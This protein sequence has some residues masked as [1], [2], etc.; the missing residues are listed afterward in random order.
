MW[1]LYSRRH[2]RCGRPS[3]SSTMSGSPAAATNVGSQSWCCTIS[4]EIEPAWICPGQRITSGM[5]KAPSQL[6]VF[7]LRNGVV[8]ASGQLFAC[9]PLS[10]R[11]DDDRVVGDARVRRAC[12]ASRRR[13]RSW[14]IIVSW[15]SD[16][17][18]PAWPTL[19]GLGWVNR[20][21]WVVLIHAK[22]GVS[23]GV[24]PLDEVERRSRRCRRR[25]S[26]SA[27]RRAG[28]CPRWSACRHGPNAG[29]SVGSSSSVAKHLSTPRGPPACVEVG[30]VGG[31]RVVGPFGLLLGV[32]VVEVAVELVEAVHG[33]QELVEVAEVVLAE[34]ARGVTERLEQFGDGGVLGLQTDVDAGHADLAH[35]RSGRRFW[36][37]MN[38][39]RPAVQLCSP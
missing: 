20:C 8:P 6:V 36:P 32:E 15:Y 21:M 5:R 3:A 11:V 16:C 24:L 33:R 19:S 39:E 38:A 18:R 17:Q 34:L 30:E 4:L 7:S 29:R 35:S 10:V 1:T 25:S 37:V 23:A 27:W 31:R 2:R 13:V 28:R 26:P 22:N 9:G 14:S 12:R